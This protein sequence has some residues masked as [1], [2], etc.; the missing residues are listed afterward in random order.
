[1]FHIAAGNRGGIFFLLLKTGKYG[2]DYHVLFN[3]REIRDV[4]TYTCTCI[5]VYTCTCSSVEVQIDLSLPLS[6]REIQE[7]FPCPV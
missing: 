2:Q 7:E 6:N 3:N 5:H 4:I 1:M